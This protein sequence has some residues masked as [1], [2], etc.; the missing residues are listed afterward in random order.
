MFMVVIFG[1][2]I[3]KTDMCVQKQL[4]VYTQ[5]CTVYK[6]SWGGWAGCGVGFYP[7]WKIKQKGFCPK[8]GFCP[9]WKIYRK[10]FVHLVKKSGGWG[11][12]GRLCPRCKKHGRDYVHLYK[13][14]Q[15]GFCPG[16]ILSYTPFLQLPWNV[17][18]LCRSHKHEVLKM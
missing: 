6:K 5:A 9:S 3:Y 14:E 18:N 10:D 13:N 12:G 15:K 16:G 4:S 7:S 2:E 11:W 17:L 1:L 8:K